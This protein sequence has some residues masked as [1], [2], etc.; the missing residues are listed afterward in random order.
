MDERTAPP[1]PDWL[2]KSLERSQAQI[3]AGKSVPLKLFLDEFRASIARMKAKRAT[4]AIQSNHF[5][6]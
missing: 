1:P 2:V 5:P 3:A 6:Y 4:N